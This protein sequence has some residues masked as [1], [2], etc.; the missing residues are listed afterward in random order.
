MCVFVI[1]VNCDERWRELQ[2]VGTSEEINTQT[3]ILRNNNTVCK[4]KLCRQGERLK[5]VVGADVWWSDDGKQRMF[6]CC[7]RKLWGKVVS[8]RLH[9]LPTKELLNLIQFWNFVKFPFLTVLALDFIYLF[10]RMH[11]WNCYKSENLNP[12]WL[13]QI[14]HFRLIFMSG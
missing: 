8:Y 14:Q 4:S 9:T 5:R 7:V 3:N 10:I 12:F 2:G 13:Y 11:Y 6:G 1:I